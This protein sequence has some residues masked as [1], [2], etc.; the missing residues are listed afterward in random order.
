M[1]TPSM[2]AMKCSRGPTCY[3]KY[4]SGDRDDSSEDRNETLTMIDLLLMKSRFAA[5]PMASFHN[6]KSPRLQ[7]YL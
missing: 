2:I 1:S 6:Q 4:K 5:N 3:R 7:S